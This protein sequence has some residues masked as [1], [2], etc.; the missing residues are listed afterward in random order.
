MHS[1][2]MPGRSHHDESRLGSRSSFARRL[3]DLPLSDRHRHLVCEAVVPTESPNSPVS[4]FCRRR[5]HGRHKLHDFLQNFTHECK[6]LLRRAQPC[7]SGRMSILSRHKYD[8]GERQEIV[9]GRALSR[10]SG[11]RSSA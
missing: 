3:H 10:S 8:P 9:S 5:N 1:A 7:H 11:S 6:P 2:E 4:H